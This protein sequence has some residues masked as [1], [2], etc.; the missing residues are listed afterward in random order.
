MREKQTRGYLIE[1]SSVHLQGL[2]HSTHI[3]IVEI[4]QMIC[5]LNTFAHIESEKDQKL[6][7]RSKLENVRNSQQI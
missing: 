2:F 4:L 1:L 7:V 6:T 5:K 3:R